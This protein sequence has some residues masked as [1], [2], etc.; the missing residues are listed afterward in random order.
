MNI[1]AA[2]H[3]T[4]V[5]RPP[6]HPPSRPRR[7]RLKRD[8][9]LI[10]LEE[11]GRLLGQRATSRGSGDGGGKARLNGAKMETRHERRHSR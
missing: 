5:E 6:R 2:N 7:A 10:Q 11:P 1:V 4:F 9:R 8:E 3:L